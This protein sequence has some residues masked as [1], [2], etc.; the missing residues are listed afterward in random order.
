MKND[1]TTLAHGSGG[2]LT[3]ELVKQ[4]FLPRFNN[5]A[6]SQLGDSA[7]LPIHGMRIAFTTD[8]YVVKPNT[9]RHDV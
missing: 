9:V 8:S 4:L 5:K 7:I 1:K 3:H 2:K 6:L